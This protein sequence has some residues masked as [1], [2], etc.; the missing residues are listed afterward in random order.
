M[1]SNLT[2]HRRELTG[3]IYKAELEGLKKTAK[4][5]VKAA[6]RNVRKRSH[7]LEKSIKVD[8]QPKITAFGVYEINVVSD[9]PHAFAQEYGRPDLKGYGYTPYIGPAFD[10]E[11]DNLTTH[12]KESFEKS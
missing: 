3:K 10:K 11:A 2:F 6:K 5:V 9:E 8:G 7:K 4:N 12:I 1:A